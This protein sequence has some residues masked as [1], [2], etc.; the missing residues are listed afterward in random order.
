[1]KAA[2][3]ISCGVS[4][5]FGSVVD[6]A[7]TRP[8]EVVVVIGAGGV[9]SGAIYGARF[10]GAQAIVVVD[11]LEFK[12]DHA[13]SLGASHAVAS[14]LDAHFLVSEL[15]K[16]RM[17]DVVVLTPGVMTGDLVKPA[18]AMASKDGR[19]VL[20]GLGKFDDDAVTASLYNITV[21]NQTL[22]GSIFGSTSPRVQIP[23]LLSLHEAGKLDVERLISAEYALDDI[24][25]G[26]DDL[27]AGKNIRG[28]VTFA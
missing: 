12:R 7:Q 17:A 13:L 19:I 6:R 10:A 28:I 5:G 1:M 14:T 22:M 4:T 24:Q 3:L 2:A 9:G 25:R 11:P 26:Y 21:F 20:T 18:C 15:T 27:A 8:G 16:G 23:R